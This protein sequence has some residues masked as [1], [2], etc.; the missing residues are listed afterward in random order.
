MRDYAHIELYY[1]KI[2]KTDYSVDLNITDI[3][4]KRRL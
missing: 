3:V 2:A 1:R 4:E